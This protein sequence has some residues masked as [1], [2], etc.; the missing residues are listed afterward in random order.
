MPTLIRRKNTDFGALFLP[1]AHVTKQ[2]AEQVVVEA[3]GEAA[4]GGHDH[5]ADALDLL[6]FHQ[7][8]VLELGV[9][10]REMADDLLH[11]ARVRTR[12]LHAVL[13][14]ADL[15]S[16]DHFQCARHLAGVLHRLDLGFDFSAACHLLVP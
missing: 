2:L 12:G 16:R 4:V 13:R 3:A 9:G 1:L 10:L 11:G 6:A 7:I 14:L 5:V 8:R 15:G